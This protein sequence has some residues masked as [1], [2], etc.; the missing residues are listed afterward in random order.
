MQRDGKRSTFEGVC[1]K[2]SQAGLRCTK[3]EVG[4]ALVT[5]STRRNPNIEVDV[6]QEWSH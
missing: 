5:S 1:K 6:L 2:N 3:M 4:V